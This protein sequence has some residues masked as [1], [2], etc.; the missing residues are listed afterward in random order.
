MESSQS[1]SESSSLQISFSEAVTVLE[2]DLDL[3]RERFRGRAF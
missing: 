3:T 1:A 2:D